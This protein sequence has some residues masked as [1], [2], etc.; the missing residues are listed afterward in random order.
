MIAPI[1]R[2][3]ISVISD[4]KTPDTRANAHCDCDL[5]YADKKA[6][7]VRIMDVIS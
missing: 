2:L 5:R 6:D 4:R 3:E 7:P 1:E